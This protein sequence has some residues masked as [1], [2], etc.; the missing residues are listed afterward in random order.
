VAEALLLLNR[1]LADGK[2]VRQ[3]MKDW[4][5]HYRNLLMAK[6]IQNP[7]NVLN[8]S[9]ENVERIREQSIRLDLTTIN[10]CILELSRTLTEA[11]WSTQPRIL[12]EVCMVKLATWGNVEKI[13]QRSRNEAAT[14]D[15][16]N[17]TKAEQDLTKSELEASKITEISSEMSPRL[18]KTTRAQS[19]KKELSP[20]E[21]ASLNKVASLAKE[22]ESLIQEETAP[23]SMQSTSVANQ[24]EMDAIWR[25]VF[26]EGEA[27]KGS[28]NLLRKGSR[29]QRID[30]N[31]FCVEVANDLAMRYAKD[32]VQQLVELMEKQTGLKLRMEC[33]QS[34][35]WGQRQEQ[36]TMEEVT[37]EIGNRL[38]INIE[39]K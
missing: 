11:K 30:M 23:L 22:V 13:I 35:D 4:I 38:G 3:F 36:K 32:N 14:K 26:E 9:A 18:E 37:S 7:E 20:K 39:I 27:D 21:V 8:V 34:T 19:V 16:A 31:V 12:L 25:R 15:T 17:I 24:Q 5:S 28:F 1:V 29:L 10:N 33:Q 6:F 2:D